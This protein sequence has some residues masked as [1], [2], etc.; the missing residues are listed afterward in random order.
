ME[1]SNKVAGGQTVREFIKKSE[2]QN[3]EH[4]N[5]FDLESGKCIVKAHS[6]D[7]F[8]ASSNVISKMYL[9]VINYRGGKYIT[10]FSDI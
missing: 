7:E 9:I 6:F 5:I 10:H 3:I 8:L 4:L 2:I 1:K